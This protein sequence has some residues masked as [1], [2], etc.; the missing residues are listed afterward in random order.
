MMSKVIKARLE[1]LMDRDPNLFRLLS[2]L[3]VVIIAMSII[4]PRLFLSI[5]NVQS[6]AY[7][8]PEFGIM[9]IGVMLAMIVGGLIYP[10]LA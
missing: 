5:S 1:K 6:M 3:L 8:L 10:L 2:M 9:A 7:Q 4:K